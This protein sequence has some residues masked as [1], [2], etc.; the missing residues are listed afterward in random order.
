MK[1]VTPSGTGLNGLKLSMCLC[2]C[3][4]I[5]LVTKP[6]AQ[7]NEELI[8]R[9]GL[10]VTVDGRSETDLRIRDG[11]IAEIG[12]D[13][14]SGTG[15]VEIDASGM[16]VIP[17]GI[18]PH[19]HLSAELPPAESGRVVDDY[20][21]GTRAAVVGGVTTVSTFL[22]KQVGE[23][24]GVFIDREI[25]L[26]EQA[27]IADM[28]IHVNLADD[29]TWVTPEALSTMVERGFTS[30]KTFMQTYFDLKAVDF[31]KAFYESGKAGV[32][33]MIH[34]EDFSILKE[35]A[36][37][38][39]AE[40]RGGL[41]NFAASRPAITEEVATLRAVAIAETT[42]APVYLVHLSAEEALRITAE[43]QA[44]GLPVYVETRPM[45]LH[46]T[47]ERFLQPLIDGKVGA[48]DAA[49]YVGSPPLRDKKDQDALWEG[50]ANGTI[51]TVGT[52]HG[53]RARSEKLD[54][55]N[56]FVNSHRGGITN[57]QVYL[58]MLYSEG[59]RTNRITLEQF[60]AVSATNPA[61]LFGMYPRKGT[62]KVGSDADVVIWDPNLKRTIRGEDKL[63][64]AKWSLYEGWEVVG[65]PV[66]TI[67]RGE[68]VYQDR[69]VIGQ[70]GSGEVIPQERFQRPDLR[71]GEP[72]RR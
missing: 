70:P 55:T 66:T 58:P 12:Q 39:V 50:I 60:V 21:S 52:D 51:H 18:D 20:T 16:F 62:I 65:W 31:V 53:A 68:I 61:K 5:L 45:F 23:D 41:H 14:S 46:H 22:T 40:G 47:Q 1:M 69:K 37:R 36:D 27:L 29:P 24:V 26:A 43:A 10:V 17:G 42:G 9:N 48:P 35:L 64:N 2:M 13:L 57:L 34:A 63:S 67:R 32:L 11:K 7:S 8:I 25:G 54:P 71:A 15:A 6:I 49:F 44:R 33:S 30:T 28:F 19:S 3:I 72:V 56:H 4:T 59:V 38:M